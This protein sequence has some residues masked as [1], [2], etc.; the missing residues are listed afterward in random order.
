[1]AEPEFF[2]TGSES[3][4]GFKKPDK[5][6]TVYLLANCCG[7]QQLAV[8]PIGDASGNVELVGPPDSAEHVWER[9]SLGSTNA[10]VVSLPPYDAWAVSI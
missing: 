9:G 4:L 10:L 6:R 3:V 5:A 7:Q 2:D 1:M 8:V